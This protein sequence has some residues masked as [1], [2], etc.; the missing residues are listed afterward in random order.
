M[1]NIL[2][3]CTLLLS[4]CASTVPVKQSFPAVPD[5]LLEKCGNLDT[6]DKPTV[7]LSEF[8]TTVTKNYTKYHNC[9]DVVNAW[10]QWYVDQKKISD[11]L[12]K[13]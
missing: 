8:M 13:K 4:G 7:L 2:L 5:L 12:N 6:I 1:K 3:L 10:Q 11:Y 9:A